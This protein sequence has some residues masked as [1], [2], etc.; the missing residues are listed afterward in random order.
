M[1]KFRGEIVYYPNKKQRPLEVWEA[2]VKHTLLQQ[3]QC[4]V[5]A[6]VE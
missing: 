1:D 3:Q 5:D 2:A 6:V 4:Y